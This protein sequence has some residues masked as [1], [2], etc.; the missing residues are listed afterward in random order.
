MYVLSAGGT[1]MSQ[2]DG[3]YILEGETKTG[4]HA[5]Q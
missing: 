5:S 1:L 4:K 3:D 2:R